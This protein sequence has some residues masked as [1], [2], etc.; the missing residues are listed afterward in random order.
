MKILA[1][2]D[3]QG[4][5]RSIAVSPA[6]SPPA[7]LRAELGLLVTEVEAPEISEI[8]LHDPESFRRLDEVLKQFRVAKTEVRLMRKDSGEI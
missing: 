1:M 6:D 8:D 7:Q 4:N 5:I 2:H 3:V